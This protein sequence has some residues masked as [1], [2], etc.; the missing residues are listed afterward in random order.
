M[1]SIS[2]I[3][4]VFLSIL[5]TAFLLFG[6]QNDS[7]ADQFDEAVKLAKSGDYAGAAK[8]FKVLAEQGNALAQSD[9]GYMYVLGWGVPQDYQE[10]MK[11]ARKAAEQGLAR[12]QINLGTMYGIG[13]GV[14]QDP[15][16]AHKWFDLAASGAKDDKTRKLAVKNR[17]I[18]EMKMTPS[19]IAEARK[20]AREWKPKK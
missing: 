20:L 15:I 10:A 1:K 14:P 4:K 11:W 17:N 6:F 8:I 18:A 16:Q 13:Q 7:G 3:P 5:L 12:A 2:T 9:L 19:Q